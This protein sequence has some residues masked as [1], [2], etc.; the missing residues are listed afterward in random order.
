[1]LMSSHMMTNSKAYLSFLIFASLLSSHVLTHELPEENSTGS[2]SGYHSK[3]FQWTMP[4]ELPKAKKDEYT[5]YS[6][7]YFLSEKRPKR[8]RINPPPPSSSPR[9]RSP[10]PLSPSQ[11]NKMFLGRPL[12]PT[13]MPPLPTPPPISDFNHWMVSYMASST[14]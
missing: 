1:M 13:P 5:T 12:D 4:S 6:L 2:Y 10:P 11:L 9:R 14:L 7:G 3:D 8:R